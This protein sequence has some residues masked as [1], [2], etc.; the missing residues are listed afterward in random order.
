MMKKIGA[1]VLALVMVLAMGTAA[2]AA[3]DA[4]NGDVIG[5]GIAGNTN[6]VWAEEDTPVTQGTTLKFHKEITV[7]NPETCVVNAPAVTYTYSIAAGDANKEI[8]DDKLNHEPNANVKVLTKAGVGSPTITGFTLNPE[9]DTF[10]ASEFGTANWF[11]ITVNFSG[12]NFLTAGTGAG[13]YRYVITETTTIADKNASGIKDGNGDA[14]DVLY[15]DVYVNGDGTIYGYVLFKNNVNI[16]ATTSA[17]TA[18]TAAGKVEGYINDDNG[19][20]YT[21]DSSTADKYFTFNLEIKKDVVND[22]YI[23][24]TRHQFP[25]AVTFQNETVTADVLPIVEKTNTATIPTLNDAGEIDSFN[26]DGTNLKI[27]DNGVVLFK[28]LPA[29]TTVTIDEQNTVTGTVYTVTTKGATVNEED[30]INLSWNNWAS[31]DNNWA[32][33]TDGSGTVYA[34][35]GNALNRV[36]SNFTADAK[37]VQF[38]N[39]LLTIS[40]TG[41]TLRVAPYILMLGAGIFLFILANKRRKAN[42]EA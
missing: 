36:E 1:L 12:V 18:A 33:K 19:T 32:D 6:G 31:G 35:G 41:V 38:I 15:L 37:R 30:G 42:E 20:V 26:Q 13:V 17:A 39:T 34:K 24:T 3:G 29:G 10:N 28:G 16:D 9:S 21:S 11:D 8:T 23:E 7:Y 40:P 14:N 27:A 2:F 25:F 22:N 5:D 4:E